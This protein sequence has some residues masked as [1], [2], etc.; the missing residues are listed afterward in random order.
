MILLLRRALFQRCW[1]LNGWIGTEGAG[2]PSGHPTRILQHLLMENKA[3]PVFWMCHL[4]PATVTSQ[5][6][7]QG[8][9][10]SFQQL[11][12]EFLTRKKKSVFPLALS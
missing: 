2:R 3:A 7:G 5:H 4:F 1:D 6:E 9:W 11:K 10:I 8:S 12:T